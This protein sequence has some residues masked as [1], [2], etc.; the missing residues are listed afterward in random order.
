MTTWHLPQLKT[1]VTIKQRF[2]TLLSTFLVVKKCYAIYDFNVTLKWVG[3]DFDFM[4]NIEHY[5]FL[6]FDKKHLS[7]Y[8]SVYFD[9]YTNISFHY[10]K[11][12]YGG[13]QIGTFWSWAGSLQRDTLIFTIKY[14]HNLLSNTWHKALIPKLS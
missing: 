6:T 13:M 7:L 12:F 5:V 3:Y 11:S 9:N 4:F 2:E 10:A 8:Y 1:L 14:M